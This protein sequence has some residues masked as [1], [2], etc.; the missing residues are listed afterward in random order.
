MSKSQ[1]LID[2]ARDRWRDE[3]NVFDEVGGYVPPYYCSIELQLRTAMSA[4]ASALDAPADDIVA[5]AYCLVEEARIQLLSAILGA[6]D[7]PDALVGVK[8]AP[9]LV[10]LVAGESRYHDA[11]RG[12]CC[13]SRGRRQ[14][15]DLNDP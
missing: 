8:H 4:L 2:A 6:G 11:F 1:A 12:E 13:P 7:C 10:E 9:E 15:E 3:V 5:D 14:T